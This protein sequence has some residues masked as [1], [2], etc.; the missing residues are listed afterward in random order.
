MGEVVDL[1]YGGTLAD[2]GYAIRLDII[3]IYDLNQLEPC[4]IQWTSGRANRG[5]APP[6]EENCAFNFKH[7]ERKPEALLA[8]IKILR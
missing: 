1:F 5:P 4:P 3:M 7:P 8:I 2:R 6:P